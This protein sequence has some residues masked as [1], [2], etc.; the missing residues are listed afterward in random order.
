MRGNCLDKKRETEKL[1]YFWVYCCL[2]KVRCVFKLYYW[3]HYAFIFAIQNG[4][5]ALYVQTFLFLSSKIDD[6]PKFG[7]LIREKLTQCFIDSKFCRLNSGHPISP[8]VHISLF[9]ILF[10]CLFK[11]MHG[12]TKLN[13]T[14][15]RS[16]EKNSY[17]S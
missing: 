5:E 1:I 12:C 2:E 13:P 6:S 9:P 14:F 15:W 7:K 10:K 16:F 4:P 11:K 8:N 3:F 17:L